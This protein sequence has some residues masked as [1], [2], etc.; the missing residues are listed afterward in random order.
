MKVSA[1]AV[2]AAI[3]ILIAPRVAAADETACPPSAK[4]PETAAAPE[5]WR[6]WRSDQ[7]HEYKLAGVSFSD[8]PPEK[9][10]FLN[11]SSS[12]P[13]GREHVDAYDFTAPSFREIWLICQYKDTPLSLI[14]AT[15]ARGKRCEV[16]S[17]SSTSRP[18]S[19]AISCK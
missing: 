3:T 12:R 16:V 9:R 7:S 1:C 10:V 17:Q 15:D 18:E 11:P 14:R 4:P 2:S 8:G 19:I 13:R 5:G 6:V